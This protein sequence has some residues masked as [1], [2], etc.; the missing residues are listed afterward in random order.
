MAKDY[1]LAID[2]GTQSIRALVFD[3]EGQ[4]V[5][6]SKV[7]IEPYFSK[8]AGWAEQDPQYFWQQLCKACQQL[9]P[10]LAFPKSHIKAVA[11]TTQ[12]A[13]LINLDRQG[14]PLRPAIIWLDQRETDTPKNLKGPWKYLIKAAGWPVS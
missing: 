1:L 11:L 10:M 12:R 13:T 3:L 6:K 14:K 4:L 2:N 8:Q 5:A 9:W 7:D